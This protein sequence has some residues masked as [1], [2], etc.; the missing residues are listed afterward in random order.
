MEREQWMLENM[1][2]FKKGKGKKKK[3]S[4]SEHNDEKLFA[5]TTK[6]NKTERGEKGNWKRK[7]SACGHAQAH[8]LQGE[9]FGL[10][11][12]FAASS[13]SAARIL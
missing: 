6:K 3:H 13:M 4:I 10:K 9:A 2:Q 1:S 11:R 12:D 7:Y 8:N 5:R